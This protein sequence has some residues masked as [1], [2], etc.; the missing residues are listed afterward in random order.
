VKDVDRR[1]DIV[2]PEGVILGF[3]LARLGDRA[4]A[5]LVDGVIII[6]AALV[7]A[8]TLAFATMMIGVSAFAVLLLLALF[9][10]R[11]FYF[12]WFECR[13]QGATPAKR[14]L[15]LRVIDRAGGPLSA[16][17]VFARNLMREVEVFVPFVVL[18]A[19][20]AVW[21]NAPGWARPLAAVWVGL[22]AALP[23][24]NRDHL[25]AGDLVGGTMVVRAPQVM[26]LDDLS[27][28]STSAARGLSFSNEQL[29][30]YGIY[31]L[32]VLEDL[33]RRPSRM[34]TLDEV[35][36]KIQIK[37]G[38]EGERPG[39]EIFLRAFY[40]AQRARL[41]QRLLLGERRERKRAGRIRPTRRL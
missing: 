9:F 8:F 19:P 5:F 16:D 1:R 38:W 13:W 41:E 24:F 26:L 36:R 22:L 35:A 12:T 29:D 11:N 39:A 27:G 30:M 10:L 37:I 18:L 31:E 28:L 21:P 17:A 2:T 25:R 7:V 32:Q 3:T 4:A 40:T 15:G 33:L 14:L 6:A 23:L 34:V 20:E